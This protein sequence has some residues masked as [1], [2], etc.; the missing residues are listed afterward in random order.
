MTKFLA[1]YNGAADDADKSELSDER[2]AAFMNAWGAWAQANSGALV[3]VGS[4]LF[5]K[6]KVTAEGSEDFM[7]RKTGY[8]VVEAESHDQAAQIFS[9]H[10]H[11]T[12][13]NGNWIE[14]LECPP[15]PG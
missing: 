7:D 1:I 11:L 3:D 10:P 6:K 14:V 8:A 2:R 5:R 13:M 9:E 12:L 15:I 4:P